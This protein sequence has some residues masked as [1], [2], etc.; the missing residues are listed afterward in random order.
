MKIL[1]TPFKD[2][3][4]IK[5]KQYYDDRGYFRELLREI[6]VKQKFVFNIVSFSKKNV[7]RGLHYQSKKPQGK[8]ISVVK[9]KILDVAVDLRKKSKTYGKHYKIILSDKN[10]TSV[11]IP[12]GFAHG[13]VS[14]DNENIVV[15]SCTNYRDQKSEGG[16]LWNDKDL[17]IKWPIKK[18]IIS[19]KDKLNPTF[20]DF[21]DD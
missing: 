19:K 8:F 13:F 10:E 3:L 11:F 4:I 9:G 7:I 1:K 21:K 20:K 17:K 15:Y 16:I 14:L 12:G 2:L 18:P 5:S 6:N